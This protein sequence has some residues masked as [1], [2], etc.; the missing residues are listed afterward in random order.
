MK[1]Q[2]FLFLAICLISMSC[3]PDDDQVITSPT[4]STTVTKK[5]EHNS[6]QFNDEVALY[7]QK[8]LDRLAESR[9]RPEKVSR[10]KSTTTIARPRPRV[11]GDIWGALARC[12]SG[13]NPRAVSSTGRYR[14]AFQFSI[15]T[16]QGIGE[17]GDPIDYSYEHQLAA[18]KRL[19]ARS[20]WGQWPRCS[21]RLGLI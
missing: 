12:E 8:E 19:Q 5:Q 18:A 4:T 16:W 1:K 15:A 6:K 17:T 2:I 14:G 3:G 10:S 20:G 7:S 21:R 11:Q 13:G 9:N